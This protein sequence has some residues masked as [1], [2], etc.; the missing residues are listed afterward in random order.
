MTESQTL[1][2]L[3][4]IYE[5]HQAWLD[6]HNF[7]CTKGCSACC[8]QSVTVTSLEAEDILTHLRQEN[9]IDLLNLIKHTP[10][11]QNPRLITTN[12]LARY[13]LDQQEPP[14]ENLEWNFSP[15]IFLS[16]E[17]C[18]I[19]EFRPFAC[20]SFVSTVPCSQDGGAHVPP[21]IITLNTVIMQVIEHINVNGK[22]GNMT[23][24]LKSLISDDDNKAPAFSETEPLPGFLIPEDEKQQIFPL[25]K[26]LV[27][28]EAD[29]STFGA[30]SGL[31][32]TDL[33]LK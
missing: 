29:H 6:G 14:D 18:R 4:I 26:D 10:F 33:P 32:L 27:E 31:N 13:C 19:Y 21:W 3:D 15:C 23:D 9:Q 8:T 25:I 12:R 1:L 28:T 5:K 16:N 7:I 24:I 22:W 17:C 20:R 2:L 30:L 11:S